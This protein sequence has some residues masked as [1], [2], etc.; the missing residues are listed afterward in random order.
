M[1]IERIRKGSRTPFSVDQFYLVEVNE[2]FYNFID[3]K[4]LI[5]I[6]C[7]PL[8][9]IQGS[10][11]NVLRRYRNYDQ[12][13]LNIRGLS[14]TNYTEQEKKDKQVLLLRKGEQLSYVLDELISDYHKEME[15]KKSTKKEL[16]KR[17][18]S[19]PVLVE[20]SVKKESEETTVKPKLLPKKRVKRL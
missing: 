18:P 14:F 1:S 16:T 10:I 6:S 11:R 8:D 4:S 3:R 12:L 9:H 13:Q 5:V 15:S 17:T 19:T 2:E 20:D 7:G